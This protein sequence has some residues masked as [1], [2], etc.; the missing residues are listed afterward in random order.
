MSAKAPVFS[1][2]D[3]GLLYGDG[4]FETV[5]VRHGTPFRI[6]RHLRRLIGTLEL[7]EIASPWP[8]LAEAIE[9]IQSLVGEGWPGLEASEATLRVLVTAGTGP[10]GLLPSAG[11]TSRPTAVLRLSRLER[12]VPTPLRAVIASRPRSTEGFTSGHKTFG[13]LESILALREARSR[14]AEETI[15]LDANR[16]AVGGSAANLFAVSGGVLYTPPGEGIREGVT[17]ECVM[18]I[19]SEAGREVR[20]GP[21]SA[22]LLDEAEEIILTSAIRGPVSVGVLDD[23][24]VGPAAGG[25]AMGPRGPSDGFDTSWRPV[26]GS[27]ASWL[28]REWDQMVEEETRSGMA[29][30]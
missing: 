23:E 21:V 19:A 10:S 8:D 17:R 27:V 22:G 11:A 14:G 2:A 16:H 4:A 5:L 30:G 24:A 12:S 3:R 1:V 7:L 25:E 26:D 28:R 6:G 13:Y 15:F 9:T 18:A 20:V 29:T